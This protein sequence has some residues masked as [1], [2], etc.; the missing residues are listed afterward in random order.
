[1]DSPIFD[2]RNQRVLDINGILL[3]PGFKYIE[4]FFVERIAYERNKIEQLVNEPIKSDNHRDTLNTHIQRKK[5]YT[6]IIWGLR[7]SLEEKLKDKNFTASDG[8]EYQ[9]V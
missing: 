3:H 5:I 1:M 8:A 7:E 6:E 4:R 2:E 9:N